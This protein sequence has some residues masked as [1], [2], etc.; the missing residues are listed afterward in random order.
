MIKSL[1]TIE[2]LNFFVVVVAL[3]EFQAYQLLYLGL[4]IKMRLL[5]SDIWKYWLLTF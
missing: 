4:Q 3:T 5:A 1:S 2:I